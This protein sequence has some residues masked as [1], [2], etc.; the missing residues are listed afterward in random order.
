M[1]NPG[2]CPPR[3]AAGLTPRG[4]AGVNWSPTGRSTSAP[5]GSWGF[6]VPIASPRPGRIA[7][8]SRESWTARSSRVR[9]RSS[10]ERRHQPQR[11]QSRR[12]R[13]ARARPSALGRQAVAPDLPERATTRPWGGLALKTLHGVL[14]VEEKKPMNLL[15]K[16]D[17]KMVGRHP[18]MV[19]GPMSALVY[20]SCPTSGPEVGAHPKMVA[21]RQIPG[22]NNEGHGP[23]GPEIQSRRE[24][25]KR[26]LGA[27]VT[28]CACTSR[29]IIY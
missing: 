3:G 26:A 25:A 1:P 23:A 9:Q 28:P 29:R 17:P 20:W 12:K 18:K 19:R 22:S 11:W 15:E 4:D 21:Q 2:Q 10:D 5:D 6:V 7:L 14:W 27:V 8:S 13:C 24:N 16:A